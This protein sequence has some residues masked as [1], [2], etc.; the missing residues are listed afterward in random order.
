MDAVDGWRQLAG[1]HLRIGVIRLAEQ[2]S[3][4][5]RWGFQSRLIGEY[6]PELNYHE[7]GPS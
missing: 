3:R 1:D 4:E 5:S 2:C 7:L 6:A